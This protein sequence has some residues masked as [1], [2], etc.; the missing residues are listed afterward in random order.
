MKSTLQVGAA[1]LALL[2]VTVAWMPRMTPMPQIST[3]SPLRVIAGQSLDSF[4][5]LHNATLTTTQQSSVSMV[6]HL[7]E[8]AQDVANTAHL[9]PFWFETVHDFSDVQAKARQFGVSLQ[10]LEE[11]NP[12]V[13]LENIRADSRILVY[14]LD[15]SEPPR[16]VG[17][18]NRGYLIGGMPMP[19]GDHWVVRRIGQAWG[20]PLTIRNL[21]GGFHHVADHYP[22]GSRPMIGDI[23]Y[24][25]GGPI[26]PHKS[27]RTG[28]DVDVAYYALDNDTPRF[29]DARS[30]QLDVER[31]WALFRYWIQH[32]TVEYIFVDTAIQRALADYAYSI[33]EDPEFIRA[34]IQV[35]GGNRAIIR[36][37]RGHANHFHVR[38]RCSEWDERCR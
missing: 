3:G 17:S 27:H 20:T 10:Y 2:V 31:N 34:A 8:R 24:P 30:P 26:R 33:G 12:G 9:R 25:E 14:R 19:E 38:F 16:S 22:G 13:D 36:N 35:E 1:L 11:L 5:A 18:A 28:R 6:A 37:A 4:L 7:T 23:S 21:V 15:L 29:W 32:E